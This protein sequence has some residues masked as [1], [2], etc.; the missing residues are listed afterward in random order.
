M[1]VVAALDADTLK[2]E[3]AAAD[4]ELAS[5]DV[6]EVRDLGISLNPT[7]MALPLV[8]Y[9]GVCHE[10]LSE[11]GPIAHLHIED[12]AMIMRDLN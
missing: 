12:L 8:V 7:G 2:R 9:G 11:R 5:L 1:K 4:A 10:P 6:E 3:L